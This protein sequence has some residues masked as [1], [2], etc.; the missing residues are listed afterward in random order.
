M[1]A[2]K[3]KALNA[4]QNLF[5]D[6]SGK[7]KSSE[8]EITRDDILK[9]VGQETVENESL[10]ELKESVKFYFK[11][12]NSE[13]YHQS[14]EYATLDDIHRTAGSKANSDVAAS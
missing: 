3:R 1:S 10:K 8:P 7:S 9:E 14:L 13:R 4:C 2:W 11:F 5:V 12:Y 6:G